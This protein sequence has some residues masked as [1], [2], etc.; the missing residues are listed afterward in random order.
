MGVLNEA[1]EKLLKFFPVYPGISDEKIGGITIPGEAGL[2]GQGMT[3]EKSTRHAI[4]YRQFVLY[5]YR[6]KE[7]AG[8]SCRIRSLRPKQPVYYRIL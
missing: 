7:I 3:R 5:S 4:V 2:G 1:M 8:L 6:R